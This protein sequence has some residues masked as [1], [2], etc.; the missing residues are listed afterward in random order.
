MRRP[1]HRHADG[2]LYVLVATDV[3]GKAV[4]GSDW[5][6][7]GVLYE[8]EDGKTRW[9]SKQRWET[10]FVELDWTTEPMMLTQVE[11]SDVNDGWSAGFTFSVQ[12]AGDLRHMLIT[13]GPGQNSN[14]ARDWLDWM[15]RVLTNMAEAVTEGLHI[16]DNDFPDMLGDVAAFHAK[17]GQ[18]YL[19]KP[20]L[21]PDDLFDFRTKFHHEETTEYADEQPKLLNAIERQD[22]RDIIHHLELQLDALCDAVWVVLGTADLQFN[23]RI[24]FEAWKRV[25]KA[26]MAKVKVEVKDDGSRNAEDSGRAPKYDIGKPKGW[27]APSHRD[28]L[29]DNAIFDEIF[30]TS[31]E[32]ENV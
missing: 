13:A 3:S 29:V 15:K 9:T 17:F 31:P 7:N 25:V 11:V 12:E 20:R 4:E 24:F 26:N 30:N 22:R 5:F 32:A 6:E 21:L 28:L 14:L 16:R 1:T 2:G 8:G 23:R 27:E 18:E 10:R 19:G